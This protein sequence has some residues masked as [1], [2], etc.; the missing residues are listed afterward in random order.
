MLSL[1]SVLLLA[2]TYADSDYENRKGMR[3][4][5]RVRRRLGWREDEQYE[6]CKSLLGKL[7]PIMQTVLT[8]LGPKSE[9]SNEEIAQA[10]MAAR[11]KADALFRE[12]WHEDLCT[13]RDHL[14]G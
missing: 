10:C 13:L 6:K 2:Q 12:G 4:A 5:L 14:G 11:K 9:S 1:M 8:S 7:K 3:T